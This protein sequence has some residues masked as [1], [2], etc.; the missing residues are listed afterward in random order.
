MARSGVRGT[1]TMH[2]AYLADSI[3][4]MRTPRRWCLVLDGRAEV[5]ARAEGA[6]ADASGGVASRR[7]K[8]GQ[9]RDHRVG[10]LRFNDDELRAV[11]QAADKAG[12]SLGAYVTDAAVRVANAELDAPQ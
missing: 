6:A 4:S 9:R 3:G 1:H 11:K 8:T 7:A 12:L 5:A 10:P 2:G